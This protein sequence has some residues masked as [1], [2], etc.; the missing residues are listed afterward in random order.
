MVE[1]NKSGGEKEVMKKSRENN[2]MI[3]LSILVVLVVGITVVYAA[4][5]TS[6]QVTTSNVTQN[7]ASWNVGFET[8]TVKGTA[9]NYGG[10]SATSVSCGN[11]TITSNSISVGEV[12]LT[13]P[14][15]ICKWNVVIKNTGTIPA[16]L[17]SINFEKPSSTVCSDDGNTARVACGNIVYKLDTPTGTKATLRSTDSLSIGD[18]LEPGGSITFVLD[19][20]ISTGGNISS[21]T[22]IQVGAGFTLVWSQN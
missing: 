16:K 12:K 15:D 19:S 8:G 20:F 13:K 5:S 17:T 10:S 4:L 3:T 6:L 21:T 1:E 9:T 22:V 14:G 7:V 2:L 18:I 11:A